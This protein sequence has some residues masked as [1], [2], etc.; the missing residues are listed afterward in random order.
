MTFLVVG[1]SDCRLCLVGTLAKDP[2]LRAVAEKF[3][4]PI[5]SSKDGQDFA[6][7]IGCTT[8]FVVD[9]F[10]GDVYNKL[11]KTK[12]PLLGPPALRQ[13]LQKSRKLPNNARP[14]FNL[15]MTGVVVCFTGFRNKEELVSRFDCLFCLLYLQRISIIF[16]YKLRSSITYF[17]SVILLDVESWTLEV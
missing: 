12:Q 4:V 15:A 11:Y 7:D 16:L 3:D 1:P 9:N 5:I 10:E 2:N 17:N 8:I 14:L 6:H 13:L